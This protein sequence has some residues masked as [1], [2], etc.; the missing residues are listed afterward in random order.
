VLVEVSRFSKFLH[1]MALLHAPA[2]AVSPCWFLEDAGALG[3]FTP[4]TIEEMADGRC[5]YSEVGLKFTSGGLC[6]GE[7][8][9]TTAKGR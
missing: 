3:T 4:A 5:K 1:G 6:R 2:T 8:S 9:C 7:V